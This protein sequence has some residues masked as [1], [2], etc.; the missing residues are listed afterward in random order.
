M[1]A[2][3]LRALAT[4]ATLALSGALLAPLP[5]MAQPSPCGPTTTVQEGDTFFGISQRCDVSVA[6]IERTNPGVDPND[7]QVGQV[8]QLTVDDAAA[9]APDTEIPGDRHEVR[10][11]ETVFSIAQA[12]G[13]TVEALLE[14]N[15]DIDPDSLPLGA[16]LMPPRQPPDGPAEGPQ[17]RTVSGV[18]TTEGVECQAM[19]S[20]DWELYTLIGDL[21]GY[22][23]GDVVE[24]RG[25]VQEVSICQ[26]GITLDVDEISRSG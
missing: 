14:A 7:L 6:F 18:L 23:D 16:F 17:M 22:D 9:R 2:T 12:M 20:R 19:R 8:L 13:V 25:E 4:S 10:T 26:Q 3:P 15:P 5:A 24:V 1:T 11:G 21:E